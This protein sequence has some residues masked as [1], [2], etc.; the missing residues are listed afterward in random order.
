MSTRSQERPYLEHQ[1]V[2]GK[3]HPARSRYFV[4]LV[5]Q[6]STGALTGRWWPLDAVT[7]PTRMEDGVI[8]ESNRQRGG[9]TF[10]TAQD[11]YCAAIERFDIV[12]GT[13][14][15]IDLGCVLHDLPSERF[16][17]VPAF[18]PCAGGPEVPVGQYVEAFCRDNAADC[19]GSSEA[20]CDTWI[21]RCTAE[22]DPPDANA[23]TSDASG[24]PDASDDEVGRDAQPEPQSAAWGCRVGAGTGESPHWPL[25]LVALWLHAGR[26]RAR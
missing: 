6:T 26:R 9:V 4:R 10:P 11:E 13:S 1:L 23:R 12:T 16:R 20:Q 8:V 24:Q 21:E 7:E 25:A 2:V 17:A 3:D 15:T 18:E 5:A 22:A 14:Q 19:D